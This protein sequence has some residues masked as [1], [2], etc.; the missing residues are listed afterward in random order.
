M[1]AIIVGALIIINFFTVYKF[2]FN[3]I[4]SNR[5]DF[6]D[7]VRYSFTPNII[8]LFRGEYWKDRVGEFKL[9]IFIFLCIAVTGLEYMVVNGIL[10]WIL[11]MWK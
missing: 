9:G 5:E 8:S 7:S 1:E 3:V 10:R 2:I 6:Y 11:N 4:F